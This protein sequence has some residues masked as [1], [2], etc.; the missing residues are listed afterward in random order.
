MP[1]LDAIADPW[2]LQLLVALPPPFGYP[3]ALDTWDMGP[4]TRKRPETYPSSL[5]TD[6]HP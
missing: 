5:C 3:T 2:I 6:K 4:G 1:P